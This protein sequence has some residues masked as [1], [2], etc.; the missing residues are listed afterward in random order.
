[1]DKNLDFR[2]W[3]ANRLDEMPHVFLGQE[4]PIL[5]FKVKSLD[6]EL[7]TYRFLRDKLKT[8]GSMAGVLNSGTKLIA[9]IPGTNQWLVNYG[10][11]HSDVIDWSEAD[12]LPKRNLE[13][14]A[15]TGR[16][17][18][19]AYLVVPDGWEYAADLFDD[20]MNLLRMGDGVEAKQAF[21]NS[22]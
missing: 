21:M 19:D 16:R 14:E 13:E 6:M 17:N 20:N 3:M 5:G 9:R 22:V 10:P 18:I 1:M 12:H 15:R 4:T 11:H 7:E 8:W 2:G